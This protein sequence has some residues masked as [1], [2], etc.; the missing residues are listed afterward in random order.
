MKRIVLQ[1]FF[2]C[3][4]LSVFGQE[5]S[6]GF[7]VGL[8]FGTLRGPSEQ[9]AQGD[10]ENFN[11]N[12]GF[13]VGG[14]LIYKFTDQFGIKGEILFSQRG[15]EYG[16]DGEGV[17]IFREADGDPVLGV[18]N[19]LSFIDVTNSYIELP[20]T[21]YFRFANQKLEISAGA[22]INFLV[23][24]SGFGEYTFTGAIPNNPE[25]EATFEL[26]HSYFRDKLAQD[27]TIDSNTELVEIAN[28]LN[29]IQIPRTIGAYYLDYDEKDGKYYNIMD[30]G[31][32]AGAAFYLNGGLYVGVTFNFGLLDVTNDFYDISRTEVEDF[33]YVS[34]EDKDTNFTIQ[35]SVGFSF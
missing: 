10:L 9:G 24:S 20:F 23:G 27:V 3:L 2:V 29:T 21:A 1:L 25:V 32:H 30:L 13:H 6:Y 11:F 34:R 19:R 15:V 31:L 26:D 7:R 4:T 16:Y 12:S 28:G 33:E 18:G 14:G 17:Q 5:L 22:N 8:N 35:T